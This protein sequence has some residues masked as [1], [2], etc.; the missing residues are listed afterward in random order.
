MPLLEL[1]LYRLNDCARVRGNDSVV[2]SG[3]SLKVF[4]SPNSTL[5]MSRKL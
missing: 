1:T 5:D 4:P 2:L 3:L